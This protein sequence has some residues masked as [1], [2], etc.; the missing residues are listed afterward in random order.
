MPLTAHFLN[1]GEGDCTIIEHASGRISVVDLS[2][3]K[4]IDTETAK[5]LVLSEALSRGVTT[6]AEVDEALVKE[7]IRKAA[8]LTDALEYYDRNI[9]ERTD[10]FRL[11]IT[12]PHMDHISGM[13]RLITAEPK[14]VQ[15]FWHSSRENFDL[16]DDEK[17]KQ[18]MG[19]YDRDDWRTYKAVRDSASRRTFDQRRSVTNSYWKED[20][21]E[22]WAP[23]NELV[24]T[25]VTKN[26]QNILSMVLKV[27]H[28]GRSILLGGD[29]TAEE[30]WPP[31]FETTVMSDIDILK[32][33]HHGR[34]SGYHQQSVK[35]M[36]PWL[37]ITS[38]GQKEHDATEKYR[39]YSDHTV[40]TR[41]TGDIKITIE[42]DGTVRYPAGIENH[43][44]PKKS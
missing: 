21:I 38:V 9:G 28:A 11:I 1:V 40:S 30:S 6:Q 2:N 3:I 13:N 12:H 25:A 5:E 15:N 36:S 18:G 17:W 16:D 26:D 20:Q 31:I 4:A 35:E 42:D 8:P 10:I 14:L 44:R 33:S 39:Q 34:N 37:T 22:I 43:W 24:A 27:S 41:F 32:A 23:T 7:A 19:R 29:A